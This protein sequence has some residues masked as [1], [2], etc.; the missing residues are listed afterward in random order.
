MD[1]Q[2]LEERAQ[3]TALVVV[4][5]RAD[6]VLVLHRDLP[7][8]PEQLLAVGGEVE[9]VLA[10]ISG[11]EAPLDEPAAFEIVHESNDAA[12]LSTQVLCEGLL[13]Q[14]RPDGEGAQQAGLRGGEAQ[15]RDAR[16]E[17]LGRVR[18]EL[19]QQKVNP[20]GRTIGPARRD[21]GRVGQIPWAVGILSSMALGH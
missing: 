10:P 9:G 20:N 3:L 7:D 17:L 19:R 6:R 16:G 18:A 4:E 12:G 21:P 13:A 11:I 8:L 1:P 14:P 2:P 5:R 15:G